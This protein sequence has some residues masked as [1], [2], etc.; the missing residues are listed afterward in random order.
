VVAGLRDVQHSERRRGLPG[1]EQEG[2]GASLER[3]DAFFDDR[4]GRVLD[5]RVD[6]AEFGQ[7]EQVLRMLG[8]V[9]DVRRGLVDR[10]VAGVRGRVRP[11]A[12]VNLLGFELLLFLDERG[13]SIALHRA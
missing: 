11:C 1:G 3:G 10:R 6:V 2:S 9:E 7:R 8:A 4:L 12:G 5:A 13:P